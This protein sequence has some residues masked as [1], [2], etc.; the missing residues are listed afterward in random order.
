MKKPVKQIGATKKTVSKADIDNFDRKIL[1]A[2]QYDNMQPLH[3]IAESIGLS[4][5]AVARRLQRLRETGVIQRDVSIV[6]CT[7]IGR[8][9]I[10]IVEVSVDSELIDR[11]DQVKARF[12]ACPQIQQ[13]YYVTGAVDF[14]LIVNVKDM[15][16]YE[17]LTR[18]L[19][20]LGGNVRHFST[21]VAMQTVKYDH[22]IILD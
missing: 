16:E 19:F 6:D 20:F 15:Q 14:V 10:L 21:L 2:V 8:P 3:K 18:S 5:P 12:L 4:A 11:L 9:L 13:C 17:L 1:A 22:S 7:S